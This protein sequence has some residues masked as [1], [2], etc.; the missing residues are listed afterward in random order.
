MSLVPAEDAAAPVLVFGHGAGAGPAHPWMQRISTGL[1][2]RGVTVATF[3]FPYMAAGRKLPDAASVLE[4][5]F[6]TAF[7][8]AVA[9]RPM[10]RAY[11]VGGKSMGGRIA[12]Q[13]LARPD[14]F[15]PRPAGLMCFGYPLHPPGKPQQRRDRHLPSIR[16]PMLFLHGTRD[17]FGSPQEM[18]SLV[19]TLPTA[20]L[21]IIDGGD[22]S[23]EAPKRTGTTDASIQH[24]LDSA[25]AWIAARIVP[26]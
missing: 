6:A 1:A 2:T 17:P 25:A 10:A 24:A 15:S 7:A 21:E 20:T 26:I 8:E 12:S 18:R 13:V 22:H 9:A 16:Q 23:L 19:D 11:L 4:A 5:A 3:A 14:G